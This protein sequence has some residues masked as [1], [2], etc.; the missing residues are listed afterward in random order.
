MRRV[1]PSR[2]HRRRP[3][4]LRIPYRFRLAG[5]TLATIALA[6]ATLVLWPQAFKSLVF[7]V[8]LVTA[9]VVLGY[10]ADRCLFPDSRP[11]ARANDR[12]LGR[13][14]AEYRRAMLVVACVIAMS[15]G[16]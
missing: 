15:F 3:W 7:K 16:A 8:P 10:A 14:H 13:R 9:G 11:L 2:A 12:A 1:I 4:Y 5:F 6:A